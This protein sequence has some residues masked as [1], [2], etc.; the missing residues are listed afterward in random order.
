MR[1]LIP[2]ENIEALTKVANRIQKKATKHGTTIV[3]EKV[4]ETVKKERTEEGYVIN[5]K[6][7]EVEAEG[8]VH[9]EGW[10][11][12]GTIE[13]TDAG[14]ILRS[15]S[16][17]IKIPERYRHADTYCEHCKTKR[18][19]KD[20][21]VVFN[22]ETGEFKQIGKN[23]LKEYTNG[24][25]IEQ[26]STAMEWV[27]EVENFC[28]FSGTCTTFYEVKEIGKYFAETM[29]KLGWAGSSWGADSTK[30]KAMNFYMLDTKPLRMPEKER[31]QVQALAEKIGF[32]ANN[33]SDE[34]IT[35]ALEWAKG[36]DGHEYNDYRENLKVIAN[37]DYCEWKH[38][39][40][41]ASL[42]MSYDKAVE[43]EI[44]RAEKQ[45]AK[46][47]STHIGNV[48][49]RITVEVKNWDVLTSWS[50][51]W[52]TTTMYEFITPNGDVCIWKTSGYVD[53]TKKVATI[54]GTVKAHTEF[55]GVKQT[56]LT[57]CKVGA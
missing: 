42:F 37:M 51:E 56:E 1:Y 55:N 47:T 38:L 50:N 12:A 54:K 15:V 52:G 44:K 10:A 48:G 33:I 28:H 24:L 23:C 17:E 57:R 53:P 5:H 22:E 31:E 18:N 40:Y 29:N 43:K 11:F 34:Y 49:E 3:F 27:N 9:F 16:D 32:D 20:T 21:Y 19:R 35:K 45:K 2:V 41:L 46:S 39:G 13:H 25:S 26:A 14:N 4:G 6:Y 8:K 30:N 36:W 7:I